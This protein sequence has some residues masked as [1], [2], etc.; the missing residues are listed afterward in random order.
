MHCYDTNCAPIV[1]VFDVT[2][3]IT[4]GQSLHH[5]KVMLLLSFCPSPIA[6]NHCLGDSMWYMKSGGQ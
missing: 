3:N 1:D 2:V 4:K 5:M 6:D